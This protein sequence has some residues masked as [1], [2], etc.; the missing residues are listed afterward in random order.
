MDSSGSQAGGDSLRNQSIP[1]IQRPALE[2]GP[3]GSM[4]PVVRS[5]DVAYYGPMGATSNVMPP[6]QQRLRQEVPHL[7]ETLGRQG[8]YAMGK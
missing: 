8:D 5:R 4:V 3:G 7:R 2:L 1:A 6:E